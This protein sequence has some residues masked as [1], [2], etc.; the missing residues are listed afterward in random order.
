MTYDLATNIKNDDRVNG[1]LR[2]RG[3]SSGEILVDQI[4]Q[5]AGTIDFTKAAECSRLIIAG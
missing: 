1:N 4:A 2:L 3:R 5:P